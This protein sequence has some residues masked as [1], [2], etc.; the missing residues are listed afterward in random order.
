MKKFHCISKLV[1]LCHE[2]N[3]FAKLDVL[4]I[5]ARLVE[6]FVDLVLLQGDATF[7]ARSIE[8]DFVDFALV[9]CV[10]QLENVF[11]SFF[12]FLLGKEEHGVVYEVFEGEFVVAALQAGVRYPAEHR[13]E[14]RIRLVV[15]VFEE[16]LL[17]LFCI[18]YTRIVLV[19]FLERLPQYHPLLLTNLYGAV[20]S[21]EL[22]FQC[23]GN[24]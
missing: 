5:V 22:L 23:L 20:P 6:H 9:V 11:E 3:E 12:L 4:A 8:L 17:E 19:K 14:W 1:S 15:T 18:H 16:L 2:E 24:L 21:V 10:K 13:K 7:D